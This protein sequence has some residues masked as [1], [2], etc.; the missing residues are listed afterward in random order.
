MEILKAVKHQI[1]AP[2]ILDFLGHF[3]VEVLGIE[4]KDGT[5]TQQKQEKAL[6]FAL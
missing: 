6:S 3:L 1:H 2:T 4:I 5:E